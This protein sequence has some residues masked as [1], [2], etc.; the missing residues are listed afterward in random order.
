MHLLP[1]QLPA[2]QS[3]GKA[4]V[5]SRVD[6]GLLLAWAL[7]RGALGTARCTLCPVLHATPGAQW[8]AQERGAYFDGCG[9]G[10]LTSC[11]ARRG[12]RRAGQV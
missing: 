10:G 3:V 9:T 11:T 7:Q 12:G 5:P 4:C 1:Q 8:Q 6:W 2:Q